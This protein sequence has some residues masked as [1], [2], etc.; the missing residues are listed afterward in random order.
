MYRAK[1]TFIHNIF[2]IAE[3]SVYPAPNAYDAAQSTDYVSRHF[4]SFSI[5]IPNKHR[6][7]TGIL[8]L[9]V[10][11]MIHYIYSVQARV[12]CIPLYLL[13]QRA[14]LGLHTIIRST[15]SASTIL[16]HS[17]SQLE[18]PPKFKNT[19]CKHHLNSSNNYRQHIDIQH[20]Q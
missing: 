3:S 4:P 12:I 8:P 17:H 13:F 5:K 15:L 2:V 18:E 7:R 16:P 1:L 11:Y 6:K 14:V 19:F 20:E 9:I 10:I